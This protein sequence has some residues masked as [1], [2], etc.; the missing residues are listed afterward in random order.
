VIDLHA[1]TLFSDGELVPAE[2]I[3]RARHK[4]LRAIAFTDHVDSSNYDI[5]TPN[6][7]RFCKD[8]GHDDIIG[9]PGVELTH[10]MPQMIAD[11]VSKCRNAGASLILVH[12]ETIVEPVEPGTNRAAI[13]AGVDILAHPGLITEE[14]ASLAAD[15]GVALEISGRGGH[16]FANGH[17]ASMARKT[18]AKLVFS[19]DAH[20]PSDLMNKEM[21]ITVSKA[22]G[23]SDSEIDV[24]FKNSQDICDRIIKDSL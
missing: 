2:L 5:I 24:L 15:R 9:I 13:I 4:G 19:T 23:L 10:V 6:I 3:Q 14:E 8:T 1:H 17:V 12:G 20:R 22:A 18:G 16:S 7:A 11:L 21:A